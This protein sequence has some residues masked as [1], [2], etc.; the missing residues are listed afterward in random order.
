M[1]KVLQLNAKKNPVGNGYDHGQRS[2]NVTGQYQGGDVFNVGTIYDNSNIKGGNNMSEKPF[3]FS[4]KLSQKHTIDHNKHLGIGSSKVKHEADTLEELL[5]IVRKLVVAQMNLVDER[6]QEFDDFIGTIVGM[7]VKWNDRA[8]GGREDFITIK[9]NVIDSRG[10]K[11]KHYEV[12]NITPEKLMG[13]LITNHTVG[14]QN[15]QL[16]DLKLLT[17]CKHSRNGIM[18]RPIQWEISYGVPR[19]RIGYD[20][21]C[22]SAFDAEIKLSK[23]TDKNGLFKVQDEENA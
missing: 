9:G 14:Y 23:S 12:D 15:F 16:T 5:P 1:A 4:W 8:V 17:K 7:P 13:L 22:S 10:D 19:Y 20:F 21:G 2:F 6:M 18:E 3:V 11:T